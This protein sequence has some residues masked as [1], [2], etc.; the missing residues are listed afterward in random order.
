MAP[1]LHS[2]NFIWLGFVVLG[3][4]VLACGLLIQRLRLIRLAVR[5]QETDLQTL[6]QEL[7]HRVN[8]NLA[9]V[10][11]LMELQLAQVIDQTARHP[12]QQS[13][14]RVRSVALLQQRLYQDNVP[15]AINLR[16]YVQRLYQT[17]TR[18]DATNLT[19]MLDTDELSADMALPVGLILH[20]LVAD[21]ALHAAPQQPRLTVSLTNRK[22]L[23]LEV[24]DK[25][26][27]LDIQS[28]PWSR[29]GV[30]L[31]QRLIE[32]LSE[33]VGGACSMQAGQGMH[34][35]LYIAP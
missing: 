2:F 6:R 17:L 8:T 26:P 11:G 27:S 31:P 24:T 33:Q 18:T 23:L 13:L 25:G 34:F 28:A 9:V 15:T 22:G 32:G 1:A 16:Q 12:L 20:E 7:S 30:A 19:L 35:K 4:L 29:A 10:I 14:S 21:A 3:G 5:R